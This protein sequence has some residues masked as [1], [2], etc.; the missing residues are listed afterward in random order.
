MAHSSSVSDLLSPWPLF[1]VLNSDPFVTKI[2]LTTLNWIN[3]NLKGMAFGLAL[4]ATF[5]TLFS[6]LKLPDQPGRFRNT[7]YGFLL[8]TPLGVCV[9]CAAPV[10]K[11]I[12][13]SRR[14]ELAMATMLSSPTMNIIVLT[15]VFTLFPIYMGI[16]KIGFTLCCIFIGIPLISK[17]Y[18]GGRTFPSDKSAHNWFSE[19]PTSSCTLFKKETWLKA[20]LGTLIDF[21]Q[22][23]RFISFRLIPLMLLAGFLGATLSHLLPGSLFEPEV[24]F[25]TIVIAA[26]FGILLPVPIAFDVIL[27][28]AFY[29]Q[30]LAEPIVL[31]LLCSL[32][33]VSLFSMIVIWSSVSKQ[34]AITLML[35]CFAMSVLVGVSANEFHEKYYIQAKITEFQ[36]FKHQVQ[37]DNDE[38]H[39]MLEKNNVT[40]SDEVS[41]IRIQENSTSVIYSAPF[42]KKTSTS[43]KPFE[44]L[45]G[46][47]IGLNKGFQY[48][49]RDYTDPFWIGRGTAAGD[50]NKDGWPDIVFGSNNGFIL[51][52][53]IGGSFQLIDF[54]NEKIKKHQV[55]AVAFIDLNNDSWLDIFFTT[56]NEG[57]FVV[58]NNN[59]K[60]DFHDPQL[61]PN[62]NALLTISPAF[63]DIDHNGLLDIINGNMALGVV[64]GSHHLS[65]RRNNSIVFNGGLEFRDVP[66]E[67]TSGETMSTLV[68]DINND[69]HLDI[70]FSNDFVVPDKI[71]LGTSAGFKSVKGNQFISSTPFFSMSVDSGD[72]NNDLKLD[73]LTSGT[74]TV[75]NEIGKKPID[76]FNPEEY[77]NFKGG[78]HTCLKIEDSAYQKNCL[79]VR[80]SNYIDILDQKRNIDFD[81]CYQ[82]ENKTRQQSCLLAVMWHLVTQNP[83]IK[84]CQADFLHDARLQAACQMLKSQTRRYNAS[85]LT[86]TIPQDDNNFLHKFD[87]NTETFTKDKN[88][89]HPGGWTW[90][91]KI[92]DLDN[93]G[94]QDVIN[95]EGAVRKS[96]YGWN[97]LMKNIRGQRFEQKQFSFG[98][99]SDFGLFS[100]S[101]LD[102]DNDGDLDIIGNSAEGPVQVYKNQSTSIANNINQKNHS[103]AVS[104]ID[105]RGN[106]QGIGA[107]IF[108]SYN[109]GNNKQMREIKASGGYM[110]FDPAIAYFGLADSIKIDEITINWPDQTQSIFT[111][112]FSADSHYRIVRKK[113][114]VMNEN[115]LGLKM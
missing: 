84:N 96:G 46:F 65:Q 74:T 113:S 4:G 16:I 50:Y 1:Q 99:T 66:L 14:I 8:G 75:T 5:L 22:K 95:A 97:V 23:L 79:R 9:N 61:I 49:I 109:A 78:D 59:G 41:F 6:Y 114:N 93:D 12:L 38:Q 110:S 13:K 26:L 30:G 35:F 37:K 17:L 90:N 107:K 83:S 15:M 102:I 98:L 57:N 52:K 55:F 72:T 68:S 63:A 73:I 103:V 29:A 85:D 18:S 80:Q 2:V 20:T 82:I 7:L 106:H 3:S 54:S 111:G 115:Q 112:P 47:Q 89:K 51:Y 88:F 108:I 43:H 10:F 67:K 86:M 92:V 60:F 36:N 34:W 31:V 62:N 48:G 21:I 64:T 104:L 77:S 105:H 70:Y 27:V 44:R 91:G 42:F 25:L 100:F 33:I 11:G 39:F 87:D 53:N 56:F 71:L 69:N 81:Q 101:L 94:W 24:N 40:M 76:L 32:S 58:Y 19:T 28:N 45:E